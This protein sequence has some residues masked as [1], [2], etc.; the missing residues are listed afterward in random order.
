ML[1]RICVAIVVLSLAVIVNIDNAYANGIDPPRPSS[2]VVVKTICKENTGGGEYEIFRTQLMNGPNPIDSIIFLIGGV[3]EQLSM[4]DISNISIS[5]GTVDLN[6]FAKGSLIR[7][8]GTKEQTIKVQV[9]KKNVATCLT[10]F[11]KTGTRLS[12]DLVKCKSIEFSSA[13]TPID[14]HRPAAKK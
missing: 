10:G 2:A 7:S 11:G 9:A 5:A 1:S 4:S 13:I 3:E 14:I 12:I 8:D 6:G